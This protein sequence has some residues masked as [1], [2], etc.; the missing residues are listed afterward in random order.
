MKNHNLWHLNAGLAFLFFIISC[1]NPTNPDS[2]A[3]QFMIENDKISCESCWGFGDIIEI[4][5]DQILI[6]GYEAI[7]IFKYNGLDIELIQIIDGFN[8]TS[9]IQ[10]LFVDNSTLAFG[11]AEYDGTGKVFIYERIADLW[12]FKQ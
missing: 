11:L 10:S 1:T 7:Y 12:E 6:S 2:S 4:N 3:G 5:K 8:K 9:G